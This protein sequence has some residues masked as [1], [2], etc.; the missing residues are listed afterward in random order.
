M[1]TF[2]TTLRAEQET[3][4]YKLHSQPSFRPVQSELKIAVFSYTF[5]GT[6]ATTDVIELGS[7]GVEGATVIPELSRI[8]D[9]GGAQDI[10]VSVKL[11]AMVGETATDLSGTVA[12]DNASIAFTEVA[13][14]ALVALGASDV[15]RLTINDGAIGA[16]TAGETITVEVVYV[17]PNM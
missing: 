14:T 3:A 16:V 4:A 13:G 10:D 9:T 5:A 7:L 17:S 1:A 12:F 2:K 6:E 15:L 11:T 8:R